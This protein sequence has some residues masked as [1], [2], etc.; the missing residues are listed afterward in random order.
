MGANRP[1]HTQL[2][3][4]RVC[5]CLR[6]VGATGIEPVTPTMSTPWMSRPKRLRGLIYFFV[7]EPLC[8]P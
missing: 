1:R 4:S 5:P 2:G 3:P 7:S 6:V 8:P